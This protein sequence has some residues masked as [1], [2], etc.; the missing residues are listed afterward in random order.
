M[1]INSIITDNFE[2]CFICH[3]RQGLSPH[4]CWHGRTNRKLSDKY[5]L[6]VPLCYK[7]HSDL[8]ERNYQLNLYL[9]RVAQ[10][11]FEKKYS[12]EEFMKIFGKNKL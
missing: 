2:E 8:H 5:G 6:I 9:M 10:I 3:S 1:K 12:R 11:E 7:C 4:H